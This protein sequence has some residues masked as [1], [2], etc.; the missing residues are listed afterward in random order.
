MR[1]DGLNGL[2]RRAMRRGAAVL[3]QWGSGVDPAMESVAALDEPFKRQYSPFRHVVWGPWNSDDA[4]L[5][6]WQEISSATTLTPDRCWQLWVVARQCIGQGNVAE[7][8]VYRGGSARLLARFVMSGE[9]FLFDTFAGLPAPV[10]K[11]GDWAQGEFGSTSVE[12]VEATLGELRPRCRLIPGLIPDTF[13]AIPEGTA[14]DLVHLD[15]DLY[16][17][18]LEGLRYFWPRL[19]P[20]GAVVVDDY[21][22]PS[23]IGVRHA[24]EEFG[25]PPDMRWLYLPTSQFV[26]FK[27][28]E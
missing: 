4:F 9:V 11:D 26:A 10:D 12:V 20:G 24:V 19:R 28:P 25:R 18:T 6:V 27:L 14:F 23:C 2:G 17:P 22:F 5:R 8:G 21:G 13:G 16:E 7:C 15:L 3:A 1:A